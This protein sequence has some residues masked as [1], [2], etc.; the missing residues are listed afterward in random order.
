MGGQAW[1]EEVEEEEIFSQHPMLCHLEGMKEVRPLN[2][3]LTDDLF[4]SR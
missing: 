2:I 4:I 1:E 3:Y